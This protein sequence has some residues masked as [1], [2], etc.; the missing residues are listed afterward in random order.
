MTH[1]GPPALTTQAIAAAAAAWLAAFGEALQRLDAAAAAALFLPDGHWR[2]LL[3]FT[4]RIETTSGAEAIQAAL[5]ET[6]SRVRPAGF[7]LD[8]GRMPPRQLPRAGREVVEVIF[9]FET[10]F[11]PADGVAR[12]VPDAGGPGGLRAWTVLTALHELRGHG[13]RSGRGRVGEAD[14]SRDF[15]APNW[16]D[17]RNR[18][19]AY[20]DRHPAVIVVGS[21]QGTRHRGSARRAWLDTLVIDREERVG[22][23]WRR[24]YHALRLHNEAHV[25][26]LPYMPFPPTWP[27]FIP[28]DMLANW[29][30]AYAEA[31]ELNVWTGTELAAGTWDEAAR[32][33]QA[34][35][36]RADGTECVMRPRH[37]LRHRRQRPSR[38]AEAARA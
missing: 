9:A 35:L 34:T 18:A 26:H 31:L 7:R 23:N 15:G 27:V 14:Y 11:G 36:R 33:W 10:A 20:A 6:V 38:R 24:R 5:D 3:A 12:L 17:R 22:D 29:F 1:I 32:C 2:D 13:D 19:R 37:L 16:L 4:W 21:G 25:N 28:K 8:P 30:E